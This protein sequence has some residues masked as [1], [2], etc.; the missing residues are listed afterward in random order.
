MKRFRP[1]HAMLLVA[2]VVGAIVAADL[3]LDGGRAGAT[4]VRPDAQGLVTLDLSTL[5]PS[6]VRFYRFLNA[7]NQEVRFLVGRD[8]DG[9]VQVAFDASET[10]AKLGRGFRHEGDWLVDNK[11]ESAV[12]LGSVNEGG[13]GCRPVPLA[14]RLDGDRLVLTETDIL[15]GWR[16]FQ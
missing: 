16:Y 8:R 4:T 5:G 7:G 10:H 11:C 3:A 15:R 9:A 1:I 13:R 12:R 2:V 6:E 14:H